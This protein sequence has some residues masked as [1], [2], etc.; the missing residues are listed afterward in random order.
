MSEDVRVFI[1][2][3]KAAGTSFRM[4]LEKHFG[5]AAMAYDYGQE[6]PVT[7]EIV[8]EHVYRN[9]D[10]NRFRD[11][12][13]DGPVKI[14]CGHIR[15][16]K[17][18]VQF[19]PERT[20]IFL[21]DPIQRIVS[22]YQH[23]VRVHNFDQGFSAFFHTA[24]YVNRQ[25]AHGKGIPLAEYG[26]IGIAEH[27]NISLAMANRTFGWTLAPLELNLGRPNLDSRYELD[28]ELERELQ[29]VNAADIAYYADAFREFKQRAEAM[30]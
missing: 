5:T 18:A 9:P 20:L 19:A 23:F 4:A 27:Y 10:F 1:H 8:Q 13:N 30:K 25:M 15:A 21:R 24:N 2:V 11:A 14:V 12:I 26:F 6:S 3:P 28:E 16:E 29:R 22:E 7:S 17:F